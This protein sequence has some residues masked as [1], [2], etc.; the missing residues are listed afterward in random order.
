MRAYFVILIFLFA[1][2]K[3]LHSLAADIESKKAKAIQQTIK[4]LKSTQS[5]FKSA[6]M[7]KF[8][9]PDDLVKLKQAEKKI[10]NLIKNLEE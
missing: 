8:K 4:V 2:T 6:Y 3:P 5:D 7:K 9:K 1:V 10:E